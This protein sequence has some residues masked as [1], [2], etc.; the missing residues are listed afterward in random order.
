MLLGSSFPSTR[1]SPHGSLSR[2]PARPLPRYP[3]RLRSLLAG[4]PPS[5][6]RGAA[7]DSARHLPARPSPRRQPLI[8]REG[9]LTHSAKQRLTKQ[10]GPKKPPNSPHP[11]APPP[12]KLCAIHNQGVP[13]PTHGAGKGRRGKGVGFS[14]INS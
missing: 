1:V 4:E 13:D 12:P 2:G 6:P 9:L 5:A 8:L 14:L 11:P 10:N 3:R 7:A